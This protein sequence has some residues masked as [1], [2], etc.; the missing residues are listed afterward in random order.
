MAVP[1]AVPTLSLPRDSAESVA[2]VAVI[3]KIYIFFFRYENGVKKSQTTFL[4][5]CHSC[6]K[7]PA[8]PCDTKRWGCHKTTA[9]ESAFFSTLRPRV[10]KNYQV[11]AFLRV[12]NACKNY[13]F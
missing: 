8:I 3:L 13:N 1:V 11:L 6:H 4:N 9:T 12:L 10:L 2:A 7:I 5:D